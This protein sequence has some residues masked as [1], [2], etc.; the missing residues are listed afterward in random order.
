MAQGFMKTHDSKFTGA[1][2]LRQRG[3]SRN[4]Q[5]MFTSLTNPKLPWSRDSGY[6]FDIK[7]YTWVSK[8]KESILK[9]RYLMWFGAEIIFSK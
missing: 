7:G 4:P 8:E 6:M 2:I 5:Y 9:D 3:K 1:V